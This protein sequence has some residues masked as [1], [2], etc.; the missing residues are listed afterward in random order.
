MKYSLYEPSFA[1][2]CSY[3]SLF[4]SYC[5]HLL[6][7]IAQLAPYLLNRRGIFKIISGLAQANRNRDIVELF[8]ISET[9]GRDVRRSSW[10]T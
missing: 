3:H 10:L 9:V 7:R 2:R 8:T 4:I 6:P 5:Q 1:S